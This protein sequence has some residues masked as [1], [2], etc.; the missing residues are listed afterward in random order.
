MDKNCPC[1]SS[2]R[3][4][5]TSATLVAVDSTKSASRDI[6]LRRLSPDRQVFSRAELR[7]H[8]LDWHAVASQVR[9]RRWRV[10]G[11]QAVVLHRGA[12]TIEQR[13]QVAIMHAGP[14]ALLGGR[15]A[16]L[17]HGLQ[18]WDDGVVHVLVPKGTRVPPLSWLR[19]Q[20]TRRWPT[21]A[22]GLVPRCDVARAA[23]DAAIRSPQPRTAVGLLAAVVQQRLAPAEWLADELAVAGRVRHR[24][25]LLIAL[26]DVAGGSH[27]MTELDFVRLCRR[28]DLPVPTRQVR[29][30]DATGR[31]RYLDAAWILPDG[32]TVVAEIDGGLHLSPDHYW[33]D[34][35]RDNDN[36][37]RGD[38]GLRFPAVAIHL[39]EQLVAAQLRIALAPLLA[40]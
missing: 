12:L 4:H 30:K 26:G 1:G 31:V 2:P 37:L 7:A 13:W 32:R 34:M 5:H 24:R 10:I 22:G 8:G 20:H 11:R 35:A 6:R 39:H 15:S 16:L 36:A 18:N 9:A 21:R 38:L 27:S 29:R 19:V 33:D 40:A 23:V 25:L 14:R 3:R 17:S 28:H